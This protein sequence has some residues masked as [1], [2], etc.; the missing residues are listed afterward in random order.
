MANYFVYLS[1]G[2]APK[3]A[4]P[5][6]PISTNV[7]RWV[8]VYEDGQGL[9]QM[10]G[11]CARAY[12]FDVSPPQLFGTICLGL[13]MAIARGLSGWDQEWADMQ[14]RQRLCANLS[15]SWS[16]LQSLRSLP[17]GQTAYG[18]Q[19]I[20][21]AST[22]G[23]HTC[24]AESV[25]VGLGTE[26][27]S[28]CDPWP[29]NTASGFNND[30]TISGQTLNVPAVITD[31]CPPRDSAGNL[32]QAG[33][34]SLNCM[35][36]AAASSGGAITGCEP[37]PPPPVGPFAITLAGELSGVDSQ[38]RQS[39]KS[40]VANR[41]NVVASQ[42]TILSISGG[43]VVVSFEV[44]F[45]MGTVQPTAAMVIN[46]LPA[47]VSIAGMQSLSAASVAEAR[48]PSSREKPLTEEEEESSLS[49][50]VVVAAAAVGCLG[51]VFCYCWNC[52][53][54]KKGGHR[55]S[56][57]SQ[58]GATTEADAPTHARPPSYAPGA[59]APPAHT[60]YAEPVGPQA[61]AFAVPVD[62]HP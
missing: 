25:R 44:A 62:A 14:Q 8:D 30:P 49:F 2:L 56:V 35:A 32:L 12:N 26:M 24:V 41:L 34:D 51:V 15:L 19:C 13:P 3:D 6:A 1:A 18:G 9:G 10:T 29:V 21:P 59:S 46:S 38:W 31:T 60:V 28:S 36:C 23:S 39:F 33:C 27:G 22:N 37:A 47:G 20:N 50:S 48:L 40:D 43:S 57:R 53:G 54:E 58:A 45:A 11:V 61:V 55:T 16:D 4:A 52:R 7:T 42:I 5:G 17:I